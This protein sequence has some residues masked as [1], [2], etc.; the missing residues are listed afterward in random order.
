MGPKTTL[1]IQNSY[2]NAM[3]YCQIFVYKNYAIIEYQDFEN[4]L[5]KRSEIASM[6]PDQRLYLLSNY[7]TRDSNP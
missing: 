4:L 7:H 6:S 1:S 3:E 2:S 5:N